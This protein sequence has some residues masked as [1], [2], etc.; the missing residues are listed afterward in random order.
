MSGRAEG[1]APIPAK[2][3]AGYLIEFETP[4]QILRAAS[5]VREKGYRRWDTHTPFPVHGMDV[6]MGL[7]STVLPWLVMGAGAAGCLTGL[8][9]QWWANAHNY[10]I[11][12]SGKPFW[13]I[14]ANIPVAFELTILF[15]AITAFAAMIVFNGLPRY[16]HPVFSSDRF[17]RVTSDR[18]FISIESQDPLFDEE[19][20][21]EF[22]RSLGGTCVER[23]EV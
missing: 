8:G 1:G 20:T 11:L 4:E 6:A 17:R 22:A 10:P 15:A 3:L 5:R 16:H 21:G 19:R 23:L 12:I 2:R 13:S 18:F 9:L 14:P 7:R